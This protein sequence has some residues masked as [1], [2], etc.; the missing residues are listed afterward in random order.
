MKR[1]RRPCRPIRRAPRLEELESRLVFNVGN[2]DPLF[3]SAGTVLT[4]V[5]SGA[6]A[7]AVALL[8]NTSSDTDA[9]IIIAGSAVSAGQSVFALVGYD[10][11]G[12]VNTSFGSGGT[13]LTPFGAGDAAANAL[14]LVGPSTPGSGGVAKLLA[15]GFATENGEQ[16]IALAR[17]NLDGSLDT[18]F[19]S[20]GEVTYHIPGT[21][22]DVAEAVAIEP[23]NGDI[24][25]AGSADNVSHAEGINQDMAV[26][27]FQPDGSLDTGFGSG[28]SALIDF[29]AGNDVANAVAVTPD[30]KIVLAG[31]ATLRSGFV[32][33]QNFALARL[34]PDGSLDTGFGGGEVTTNFGPGNDAA[35][36]LVLLSTGSILVAGQV[37]DG[38][39]DYMGL[40][41]YTPGGSLDPTFGVGGVTLGPAGTL[42]TSIGPSSDI[43]TSLAVQPDG[44]IVLAG[45]S[46]LLHAD[47]TSYRNF[48][49]AR[50]TA[51]GGVDTTFGV[52]GQV[53]TDVG[54]ADDEINA[55]AVTA[56]GKLVAAG[57]A[58]QVGGPDVALARYTA[59]VRP[60]A[61][62]DLATGSAATSALQG[63]TI[64]VL[65]NDFDPDPAHPQQSL[66]LSTL[67]TADN[68]TFTLTQLE[69]A[70]QVTPDG[71]FSSDGRNVTWFP[72]ADF[73]GNYV[74]TYTIT[75]GWLISPAATVTVSVLPPDPPAGTLDGTFGAIGGAIF[76][77]ATDTT[78]HAIALQPD[79]KIVIAGSEVVEPNPD[80]DVTY[81][82]FA[83]LR[84]NADGTL[85][86]SFG[87]NG[88]VVTPFGTES[89]GDGSVANAVVVQP[90]GKIV[91][92]GSVPGGGHAQEFGLVRYNTDGTIDTTFGVSGFLRFQVNAGE[93]CAINALALETMPDGTTDILAAGTSFGGGDSEFALA[94]I[95]PTGTLDGSFGGS[96]IVLTPIGQQSGGG[97]DA[98]ANAVALETEAGGAVKIIVAGNANFALHIADP[99][100][101][102]ARYNSDGSLDTSFGAG[103]IVTTEFDG[104]DI[105]GANVNAVAVQPDGSIVAA[106]YA[107]D[108]N[109]QQDIALARYDAGGNLDT[110]F[111]AGSGSF[112]PAGTVTTHLDSGIPSSDGPNLTNDLATSLAVLPG[113]DI[114]AAGSAE[115]NNGSTGGP[116]QDFVLVRY[117]SNGLLNTTFGQGG[118]AAAPDIRDEQINALAVDADGRFVVV[119]SGSVTGIQD[120]IYQRYNTDGSADLTFA[121]NQANGAREIAFDPDLIG[122]EPTQDQAFAVAV[123]P[124]NGDIILVGSANNQAFAVARLDG[125]RG[126][127]DPTFGTNGRVTTFVGSP[128]GDVVAANAVVV[129][130]DGKIVVAGTAFNGG[131]GNQDF[132][133]VRYNADGS[134]DTSFGDGGVVLTDFGTGNA[135][136]F[137]LALETM[138]DGSVDIVAAGEATDASG[139]QDFAL[140]RYTP[141][142]SLDTTFDSGGSTPGLVLT[143]VGGGTATAYAVAID[144][145]GN[146]VVA[147]GAPDPATGNGDFALA[148]YTPNGNLDGT[149]GSGGIVLT[150]FGGAADGISATAYALGLQGTNIIVA[151]SAANSSESDFALARYDGSGNLDASGFNGQNSQTP[152]AH[153]AG[154]VVT[155][156]ASGSATAFGLAV[157]S[158]GQVVAVGSVN[159]QL[160][161]ARY[162]TDGSLDTAFGGNFNGTNVLNFGSG[163]QQFG[164]G[165]ALQPDGN[166]VIAGTDFNTST[167][168]ADFFVVRLLGSQQSAMP[169]VALDQTAAT[170]ENTSVIVPVLS[171]NGGKD[172][173]AFD[174]N[175][176]P[177]PLTV[178]A[179]TQGGD[180]Q[181]VINPD[182]T[183]TY[184]PNTGFIGTDHFTYTVT[185]ADGL[186]STGS[187]AVNVVTTPT[188]GPAIDNNTGLVTGEQFVAVSSPTANGTYQG[189]LGI[190]SVTQSGTFALLTDGDV[191]V[192]SD[193]RSAGVDNNTRL[194]GAFDVSV[195]EL[196]VNV[197]KGDNYLSFDFSFYSNEY[198]VGRD[199]G[200]NDVFLA[201]LDPAFDPSEG[202][203]PWSVDPAT[204]AVTAPGNFTFDVANPG[205]GPV[206]INSGFF[207]NSRVVT[208][209]GTL[210]EA[211]LGV[212]VTGPL[213]NGGSE[214]LIA[215]TPITPGVHHLYLSILDIGSGQIDSA[216][217]VSGLTTSHVP[218]SDLVTGTRQP[219]LAQNDV[220]PLT[221]GQPVLIPVLAN[222]INFE[223]GSLTIKSTTPP[224]HGT[225]SVTANGEVRYVP[226]PGFNG[227]DS[228]TYTVSDEYGDTSTATV[229]LFPVVADSGS[230]GAPA[231]VGA[232]AKAAGAVN[233]A[234]SRT[235]VGG[236]PTALT[237]LNYLGNP[238]TVPV[239]GVSPDD[240]TFRDVQVPGSNSGDQVVA[241]F[242][243]PGGGE[244]LLYFDGTA[245]VP[246][247][248]SHDSAPLR[249]ANGTFEVLLDGTSHPRATGLPGTV[250]AIVVPSVGPPSTLNVQP[251]PVQVASS[252]SEAGLSAAAADLSLP[253]DSSS[254]PF[255]R[256]SQTQQAADVAA[257]TPSQGSQA[258][259]A[260][261][262]ANASGGGGEAPDDDSGLS[263]QLRQILDTIMN[264]LRGITHGVGWSGPPLRAGGGSP[265]VGENPSVS[266][267]SPSAPPEEAD[268]PAGQG[269]SAPADQAPESEG[270]ATSSGGWTA[271]L[272]LASG[273]VRAVIGDSRR[274]RR[275][276]RSGSPARRVSPRLPGQSH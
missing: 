253:S 14:L 4:A 131:T 82:V 160:A 168:G 42:T 126:E 200:A 59:D 242:I 102:L 124:S 112:G 239:P 62:N 18:T 275:Y 139:N 223:G 178:T 216:V 104:G 241:V 30:D 120:I 260:S 219:P 95:T 41:R 172:G 114:V 234:L 224:Q 147:G 72:P 56:N 61:V 206:S 262:V 190:A 20:G 91:V 51:D 272:A 203:A 150:P 146:V 188:L 213:Y 255:K 39:F 129:E 144:G 28:G 92:A 64:P 9:S 231:T 261:S 54:G 37:S 195:L 208:L 183:V 118:H 232:T 159:N 254:S 115:L 94:R 36:S 170:G 31:S 157:Q 63:I 164:N 207:D 116:N 103:G 48:S 53:T 177:S 130:P 77:G 267:A 80:S 151:G 135:E 40:A 67:T 155:T 182:A 79:G 23:T 11:Q 209:A 181:V 230:A 149:F 26:V 97:A 52:N 13:V 264:V 137:G 106:G 171:S 19:G 259:A 193:N 83:V 66:L 108:N 123:Q 237:V 240:T 49:L 268:T 167:G 34:L 110:T 236:E 185:A 205:A 247:L 222:D 220:A 227:D 96:G 173:G 87:T 12:A 248:G 180:G 43:A 74:F 58:D 99:E 47:G 154:T 179:V 88:E 212:T 161:A 119:G 113:G 60:I 199:D 211:Q 204:N 270:A 111:G 246:V 57:F 132:T 16:V 3:G 210:A 117:T 1:L 273:V 214:P 271:A 69:A 245:W 226:A 76:G 138:S 165:V 191:S 276:S 244:Q 29:G 45:S 136:V 8:N 189:A 198:P 73:T 90:D 225:I 142:G 218:A 75:D 121:A 109:D 229:R 169:P 194:N 81:P 71:T 6:R 35:N 176:P 174:P 196:T 143:P 89:A 68:Q 24:V 55:L 221:P 140:A 70:P 141:D 93:L 250:F 156:F 101:A 249:L 25:V 153:P 202:G 127:L 122:G 175:S 105:S 33:Q 263:P 65:Q 163:F 258:T 107:F 274:R 238:V 184:T 266:S 265:A 27:R 269:E 197:P 7:N 187:V 38:S 233:A 22:N 17:Y 10:G 46:L 251:P 158:N 148:R 78:A 257:L 44:M 84:L 145:S 2:L 215:G 125:D 32:T 186:S 15:A 192:A 256:S 21:V 86:Q 228:F 5:G 98:V 162:N 166:I 100:F 217:F 201:Q 133:L 252:S 50:Y 243:A 134:L 128:G 152:L 235:A 85:D